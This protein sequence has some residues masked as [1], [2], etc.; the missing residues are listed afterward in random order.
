MYVLYRVSNSAKTFVYSSFFAKD[1]SYIAA[2]D[3]RNKLLNLFP[4]EKYL[5]Y[6]IKLEVIE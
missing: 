4:N 1:H 2:L 5:I 6:E 3:R